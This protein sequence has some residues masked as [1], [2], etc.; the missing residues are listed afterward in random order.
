MR[1]F[2]ILFLSIMSFV[3]FSQSIEG[4][5][6]TYNDETGQ[7]K[8][9]VKIYKKDG[10]FYGKII[11]LHNLEIPYEDAKCY[12]CTDYRKDKHV[13]GMEI[14]T[15][16]ELDDDGEWKG[17]DA[18]LDPNNGKLYDATLWLKGENKLA[19]RGYVGLF[20]RTQYWKR[21]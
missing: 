4:V 14:I 1:N 3:S 2:L 19:V 16:L 9:E 15:G 6:E 18:L 5:W 7:L 8:S 20:F 12:Y 13:M 11:K 17:D 10:K 21:K